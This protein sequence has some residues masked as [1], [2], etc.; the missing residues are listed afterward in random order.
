MPENISAWV[1]TCREAVTQYIMDGYNSA[2]ETIP[3]YKLETVWEMPGD[4]Y[5][6]A[7]FR[8]D[9]NDYVRYLVTFKVD[10]GTVNIQAYTDGPM[11]SKK[12]S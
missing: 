11:E 8:T 12:A 9:L 10:D 2:G 3:E 1:E 7:L 4:T 5:D 6:K